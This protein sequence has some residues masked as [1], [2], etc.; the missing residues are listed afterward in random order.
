MA[1]E[2][3]S[4]AKLGVRIGLVFRGEANVAGMV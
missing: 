4:G 2:R 3:P 1:V